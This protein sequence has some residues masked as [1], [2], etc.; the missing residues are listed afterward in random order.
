MDELEVRILKLEQE[1][2]DLK[3]SMIEILEKLMT[4]NNLADQVELASA[5]TGKILKLLEQADI[6]E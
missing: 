4:F 6:A 2:R 1:C 3:L 5:Q